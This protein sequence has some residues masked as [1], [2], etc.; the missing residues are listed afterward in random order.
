MKMLRFITAFVLVLA[1]TGCSRDP[2]V[3]KKKYVENG[4]KYFKNGRYKEASILYRK[5]LTKDA[6]YGPAYARLAE[7]EVRLGRYQEAVRAYQRAVELLPDN[8]E[9]AAKLANIYMAA[10][11]GTRRSESLR[12]EITALL[13]LLKKKNP[14]SFEALRL[15]GY[16]DTVDKKFPDAEQSLRA[17]DRV[18]PNQP[19]VIMALAQ[20]LVGQNKMDEAEKVVRVALD[21][22]KG[23]TALYD[24]LIALCLRQNRPDDAEKVLRRKVADSP[25]ELAWRIELAGFYFATRKT[26]QMNR[27]IQ[28]TLDHAAD[29]PNTHQKVGDF[30]MR[31]RDFERAR[32]VYEQGIAAH[33]DQRPDYQKHVVEALA[34]A[35]KSA[36]AMKLVEQMLKENKDNSDARAIRAALILQSG[37]PSQAQRAIDD[38]ASA[39]QKN[40]RNFVL[41]Y[42]LG[43][44]YLA[45]GDLDAAKVQFQETL[46][47]RNDYLP[48]RILLAQVFL[49]KRDYAKSLQTA[50]EVLKEEPGNLQAH[51]I[52]SASLLGSG[53]YSIARR[54]LEETLRFFPNSRDAQFQ[55]AMLNLAE[56]RTAEAEKIFKDMQESDRRDPRGLLG[57]VE[58]YMSSNRVAQ[59][60]QLLADEVAKDP[61][62]DDL[63]LG[64]ANIAY[65][66]GAYDAAIEN[67]KKL[68]EKKPNDSATWLRLAIACGRAHRFSD[69][70]EA[71]RK[72]SALNPSDPMAVVEHAMLFE[73]EG[74]RSEAMPLYSAT[75]KLQPDN[76]VALNNLAYILAEEGRDLDQAL[77]YAQRAK[78]RL[79]QNPDVADTLGWVYI[80]KNLSDNA[81]EIFRALT[82][83]NPENPTFRYHLA[84]A[85]VQKGD[86]GQ[87]RRE[88]DTALRSKPGKQVEDKIRELMGR[89]G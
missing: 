35:G 78:Q 8:T 49:S 64:L 71:F 29:F 65:R 74:K 51:L 18:K 22:N 26:D 48:A 54:E 3:L 81:I 31:T 25:K 87:A 2:E 80:K 34:A 7:A 67:Y 19:E 4:D 47:L 77:T 42:N 66:A 37:D 61:G 50:A 1:F 23:N 59:A 83:Q 13:D 39:L 38:F 55:M 57:L 10:Y 44:A 86:K 5:A 14:N 30:F 58:S 70:H 60:Q 63:R 88:L 68:L 33:P 6:R 36:D 53:E 82:R 15:K 32:Q 69:A 16:I 11:L 89:I 85:Y 12:S 27:T 9:Q 40:P 79:P 72:A 41:Q 45:K 73:A 24:T 84:L 43:R 76:P 52:R 75:L 21:A 28:E 46:K 20:A 17:A 56:H 62:R